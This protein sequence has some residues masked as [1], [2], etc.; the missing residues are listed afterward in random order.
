MEQ[1]FSYLLIQEDL[2][3]FYIENGH[4]QH[5]FEDDYMFI[6]LMSIFLFAEFCVVF[7]THQA[8]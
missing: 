6:V 8:F 5:G 4:E 2:Q 1:K 7:R 3:V